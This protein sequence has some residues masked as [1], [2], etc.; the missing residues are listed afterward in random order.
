MNSISSPNNNQKS[1]SNSEHQ[2]KNSLKKNHKE[3]KSPVGSPSSTSTNLNYAI[4]SIKCTR[5]KEDRLY[6]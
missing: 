2:T 6:H 3:T 4:N 5:K 1:D